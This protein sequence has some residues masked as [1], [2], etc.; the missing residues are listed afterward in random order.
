[1][2]VERVAILGGGNGGITAAADLT[3]KGFLVNIFESQKFCKDLQFIKKNN[4][5]V[6]EYKG[7]KSVEK[8]NLITDDLEKAIEGCQI[9]MITVPGMGIEYFAEILAPVVKEE[10]VILI[11]SAP[12]MASVR[13]VKKAKEMGIE[14]DFKIGETNSLTYATRAYVN[15]GRVDVSLKAGKVY[16]AGY[17]SCNTDEVF[18]TCV[19]IYDCFVKADNVIVVNLEN[20]NP[21]VHPGPTLLNAGRIDYTKGE[22]WLYKEGITEH[23]VNIVK[24]VEDEREAVAKALDIKLEDTK[25]ARINRGYFANEDKPLHELFNTSPVFK[26][27]KGPASVEGRYMVEDISTGLVLWSDLG[28]ALNVPTPNID[29]IIVLGG[30]LIGRDFYKEGLTLD[31]I[32]LGHLKSKED[33]LANI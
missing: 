22:F 27:I 7:N 10:Q 29:S 23:T 20:P 2:K 21:L 5:I 12:A 11:N 31:S 33:I 14:K 15:E 18:N 16:L 6:I 8:I 4:E 13:F 19:Q 3:Q 26:Y 24:A 25:Q 17:P 1:M 28:K 32:G 9:I 30:T